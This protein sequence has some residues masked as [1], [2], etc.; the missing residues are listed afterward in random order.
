MIF[1]KPV[2]KK[3]KISD[4][5]LFDPDINYNIVSNRYDD[6]DQLSQYKNEEAIVVEKDIDAKLSKL[7]RKSIRN[8][9]DLSTSN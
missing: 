7:K 1:G 5:L 4:R 3:K 9:P 8:S 2:N 6:Y